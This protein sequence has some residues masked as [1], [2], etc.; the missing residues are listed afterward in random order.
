M[1][2]A[3]HA[4]NQLNSGTKKTALQ[5][6]IKKVESVQVLRAKLDIL[7]A[8]KAHTKRSYTIA[9]HAVDNLQNT[10]TKHYFQSWLKGLQA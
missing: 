4:T 1:D 9:Q 2:T 5:K 7:H 10:Q 6:R 3:I 8:E